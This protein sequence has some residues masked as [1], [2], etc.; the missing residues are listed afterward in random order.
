MGLE[1]EHI[2]PHSLDA[3]RSILGAILLHH[4]A[5]AIAADVLAPDDFY[6]DAHR[7][8]YRHFLKLAAAG[9]G[10]D[11]VTIT[12]SLKA[13]GELDNIGGPVYV[14]DVMAG[15]PRST[16]VAHYA[17]I[18]KDRARARTLTA[19]CAQA[20]KTF[21]TDP[22]ALSDGAGGRF[23][24]AVQQIVDDAH[25]GD[26][27]KDDPF[28]TAAELAAAPEAE[29]RMVAP[30]LIRGTITE[31]DAKIKIGKTSLLAYIVYCIVNGLLCFGFLVEQGPVLWLTEER[32][33][34]FRA[35]LKRFGLLHSDRLIVL[36]Y[37]R[38]SSLP[39][40]QIMKLAVQK[41][42]QI[43][44]VTVIIDTLPQFAGLKG[45]DENTQGRRWR[46]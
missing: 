25:R 9:T 2:P 19:Y 15:I 38:V 21:S 10:I 6:R 36:S 1:T 32:P 40:P 34:T 46:P 23:A 8:I 43:Q 11:P 42:R 12:E 3:E 30:Y 26:R 44:A 18:V 16:N 33:Q 24:A 17:R 4:E 20:I 35:A 22:T 45:D 5:L 41:A 7:T 28:E 14:A 31:L 13:A 27:I 39:W 29:A 37:W